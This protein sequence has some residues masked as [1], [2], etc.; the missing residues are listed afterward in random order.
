LWVGFE[1]WNIWSVAKSGIGV[2]GIS[3]QLN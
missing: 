1:L 3:A 2:S